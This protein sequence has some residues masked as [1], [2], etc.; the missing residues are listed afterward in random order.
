M[1]AS[2]KTASE[3]GNLRGGVDENFPNA[4]CLIWFNSV[5]AVIL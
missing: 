4:P 3:Q 5:V 2:G 1:R